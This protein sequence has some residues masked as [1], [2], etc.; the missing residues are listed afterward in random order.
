MKL[1]A[2]ILSGAAFILSMAT[3]L[4]RDSRRGK[5]LGFR[6]DFSVASLGENW[7]LFEQ[8]FKQVGRGFAKESF[9]GSG[10]VGAF[11]V[12]VVNSCLYLKATGDKPRRL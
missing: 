5:D 11:E 2:K 10:A 8:G 9:S 12:K 3:S 1:S 4:S 6:H 7:H